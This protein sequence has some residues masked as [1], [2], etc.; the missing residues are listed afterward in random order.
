MKNAD[1]KFWLMV[2]FLL[3]IGALW[4]QNRNTT[5]LVTT[6]NDML[7]EAIVY[8]GFSPPLAGRVYVYSNLAIYQG[9][10]FTDTSLR[11]MSGRINGFRY[12]ELS[13]NELANT[14]A[15]IST[16]VAFKK[17]AS[18]LVFREFII[19]RQCDSL[20]ES[21]SRSCS[22]IVY[23]LSVGRG[24]TIANGILRLMANDRYKE[25]RN[26]PRFTPGNAWWNWQPTAPVYGEALEPH[27]SKIRSLLSD[28]LAYFT[29]KDHV[30]DEHLDTTSAFYH[31]ALVVYRQQ[32]ASDTS[33]LSIAK[34]W[35]C[36]PQKTIVKGHLMYNVRQLTPGGHWIWIGL[37]GCRLKNMSDARTAE[38]LTVLSIAVFEGFLNCWAE[39]YR[40]NLIRPETFIQK[41]IDPR[42]RPT[43]ETPLFPEHPSGHSVI[44]AASAEVLTHFLGHNMKYVDRS[45]IPFGLHARTYNSFYEASQEAAISRVYGGIHYPLASSEGLQ[46]GK[47]VAERVLKKLGY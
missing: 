39:K 26:M 22:P 36:N 24:D 33:L 45:E 40:T 43:L 5:G 47:K 21:M 41:H 6:L 18:S 44:S 17:V 14:N 15:S 13:I 30:L 23:A 32:T 3:P 31:E 37:N 12:T 16:I 10:Y 46:L 7:T 38:V 20:L 42:W 25:T 27:F 9:L 35:D 29:V 19:A 11:S 28:S 4:A 8:D 34:F 1:Y 2:I